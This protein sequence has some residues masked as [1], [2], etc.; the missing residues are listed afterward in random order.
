M[1]A[2]PTQERLIALGL[3]GMARALEDRRRSADIA[4]LGFEERLGLLWREWLTRRI[5]ARYLQGDT[6]YW[7]RENAEL[8]NPDQRIADDVRSYTTTTLSLFLIFLNGSFTLVAFSGVLW[9]ISRP[10]F[11]VA[12]GYAAFGSLLAVVLGRPALDQAAI[13]EPV[14]DAGHVRVVTAEDARELAH[15]HRVV[16]VE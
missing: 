13:L 14:D 3:T 5:V 10:L 16:R 15:R 8:S 7:L 6:Y 4:A 11:A 1:L 12:V 2:H 9:S